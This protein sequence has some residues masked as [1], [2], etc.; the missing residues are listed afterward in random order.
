M[1]EAERAREAANR[2]AEAQRAL[3]EKEMDML[4]QEV[5]AKSEAKLRAAVAEAKR[6]DA[7]QLAALSKEKETEAAA[8]SKE[9]ARMEKERVELEKELAADKVRRQAAEEASLAAERRVHTLE[10]EKQNVSSEKRMLQELMERMRGEH[11]ET[12][13]VITADMRA[14][15]EVRKPYLDPVLLTEVEQATRPVWSSGC[16]ATPRPVLAYV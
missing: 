15:A 5:K 3:F 12:L 6:E 7:H 4:R 10:L 8:A 13:D 1:R 9:V 14:Q 16:A 11:R 2:D